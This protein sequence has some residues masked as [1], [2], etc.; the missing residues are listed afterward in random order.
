MSVFSNDD[1]VTIM[2]HANSLGCD[3]VDYLQQ[4]EEHIKVLMEGDVSEIDMLNTVE[5]MLHE[6]PV[7][8]RTA[9]GSMDCS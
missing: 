6:L 2:A 7:P 5:K 4:C 8:R 9:R 3:A 1:K